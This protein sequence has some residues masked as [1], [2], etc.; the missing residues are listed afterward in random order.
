M[1][2]W[3]RDSIFGP[4]PRQ[5]LDRERRA[6]FRFLVRQHRG[7]NRLT[8]CDVDVADVLVSA[9]GDDGQL[10]PS[11]TTIAE[12]AL[13]H[14]ATVRRALGRLRNLGLVS[15][16]R[17]LVRGSDTGWRCEQGSNAYVLRT[18]ACDAHAA[19]P[20]KRYQNSRCFRRVAAGGGDDSC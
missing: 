20:D 9:L 8:A 16:V 3:H 14:V 11:H 6:R 15:W 1:P 4:G 12:R 10:D 5:P 19:R 2:K 13:C 7:A 17:R 18:P